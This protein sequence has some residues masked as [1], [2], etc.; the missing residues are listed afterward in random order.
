[1]QHAD[2]CVLLLSGP[3]PES[4]PLPAAAQSFFLLVFKKAIQE[5]TADS[6]KSVYGMLN[7]ACRQILSLLPLDAREQFDQELCRILRSNSAGSN[8]MLQLWSYGT[9][10]CT[11]RT[12]AIEDIQSSQSG[13]EQPISIESTK[14][15]WKTIAG[16]K[17]FSSDK[18]IKLVY[19][20]VVAAVSAVDD[21]S[22]DAAIEGI[23]I[24]SRTLRF[25][26]RKARENWP[27]S[28]LVDENIFQKLPERMKR[29]TISPAVLL[30]ALCFYTTI[31]D[32]GNLSH[33]IVAQYEQCLMKVAHFADSDGLRE[34]L[35]L[36]LPVFAVST[37]NSRDDFRAN[38]SSRI[39]RRIPCGCY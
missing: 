6:L 16:Q 34:T 18:L 19:L 38:Q 28:S 30:E 27:K 32:K 8:V 14:R 2:L 36:S 33:E 20:N 17:L 10:L 22:D 37:P 15:K 24:A 25:V 35:A 4:V 7:G 1:M 21:V 5:P 3:L 31:A 11:E 9:V 39:C 12:E 13:P 29:K 23:R 26:D